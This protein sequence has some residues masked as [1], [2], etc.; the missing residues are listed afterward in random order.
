MIEATTARVIFGGT[1]DP[2]H[3]GHLR[4]AVEIGEALGVNQV[5]L[6]PARDPVHRG[7]PGATATERLAMLEHAVSAEPTLRVNAIELEAPRESYTLFT[8]QELRT[9]IGAETPLILVMGMDA[10]LGLESWRGWQSLLDCA[11]IL[12]LMRPGYHPS[13]SPALQQLQSEHGTETLSQLLQSA[14]GRLCLF[15]QTP[16]EISATQVR[17][18]IASGANPRYL[19]PDAVWRYIQENELYGFKR[20]E[21][22]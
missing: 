13:L 2:V 9:E 19:I 18:I 17:K 11:H 5:D 20:T 16:L 3:H 22:N 21:P 1:Y 12:V 10:F 7:V 4:A 15:E 14:A 8:L 6:I